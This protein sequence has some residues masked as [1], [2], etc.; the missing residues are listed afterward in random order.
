MGW[1]GLR[2]VEAPENVF[3]IESIPHDWLFPRVAAAVHHGGSGTTAAAL[4]AGIPMAVVP[5]FADQPFWGQRVAALGVGP[6]P[7]PRKQLTVERLATAIQIVT[8]DTGMRARAAALGERI[9][10]EDG[11]ARA[12]ELIQRDLARHGDAGVRA[13]S[14]LVEEAGH[15][16]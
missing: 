6:A 11:V 3:T 15:A 9:R 14:R 4:R 10:A 5:F 2:N 13:D 8:G 7:I 12:V 16:R 1:G